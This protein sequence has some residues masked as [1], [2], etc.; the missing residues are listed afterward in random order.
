[1]SGKNKK[2]FEKPK[3]STKAASSRAAELLGG[4]FAGV[5]AFKANAALA[6]SQFGRVENNDEY[7]KETNSNDSIATKKSPNSESFKIGKKTLSQTKKF[8]LPHNSPID[9]SLASLIKRM[10]KKDV[11]TRLKTLDE[12]DVYVLKYIKIK[13]ELNQKPISYNEIEGV[14]NCLLMGWPSVFG[15][16][17]F[18]IDRRIRLSILKVHRSFISICEKKSVMVLSQI[19]GPWLASFFDLNNEISKLSSSVFDDNFGKTDDQKKRVFGFCQVGILEFLRTSLIDSNEETF[20]DKRYS[21]QEELK[22]RYQMVIG[23]S[24]K[25][26]EFLLN[27]VEKETISKEFH[28]YQ[29]LLCTQKLWKNFIS[30]SYESSQVIFS[31]YSCFSAFMK[32][33]N[34]YEFDVN[35]CRNIAKDVI[36]FSLSSKREASSQSYL[37]DSVV[38]STKAFP[39]LW[40]PENNSTKNN[41][42][43]YLI[44]YFK[45]GEANLSPLVSYPSLYLLLNFI[46]ADVFIKDNIGFDILSAVWLGAPLEIKQ[47]LPG[48][49]ITQPISTSDP[50]EVAQAKEVN[51][52]ALEA[53]NISINSFINSICECSLFMW[54]VQFKSFYNTE[55]YIIEKENFL[56]NQISSSLDSILNFCIRSVHQG[57][58]NKESKVS[59][60]IIE[61]IF[62]NTFQKLCQEDDKIFELL[63]KQI[64]SSF[65]STIESNI[66]SPKFSNSAIM[67]LSLLSNIK[68][69][70]EKHSKGK[71]LSDKIKS[72]LYS[73]EKW[74]KLL[75]NKYYKFLL[76]DIPHLSDTSDLNLKIHFTKTILSFSEHFPDLVFTQNQGI[77][78]DF[79]DSN[80]SLEN[81]NITNSSE[82]SLDSITK[83]YLEWLKFQLDKNL[84]MTSFSSCVDNIVLQL[85]CS[86]GKSFDIIDNLNSKNEWWRLK[87]LFSILKSIFNFIKLNENKSKILLDQSL[88]LSFIEK[89]VVDLL[90]KISFTQ[91]DPKFDMA[92]LLISNINDLILSECYIKQGFVSI[93]NAV[94]SNDTITRIFIHFLNSVKESHFPIQI[95]TGEQSLSRSD[96]GAH[97]SSNKMHILSSSLSKVLKGFTIN[98]SVGFLFV[99]KLLEVSKKLNDKSIFFLNLIAFKEA[100]TNNEI[101]LRNSTKEIIDSMQYILLKSS[102]TPSI[103]EPI[104]LIVFYFESLSKDLISSITS[105]LSFTNNEK[106]SYNFNQLIESGICLANFAYSL[107]YPKSRNSNTQY[108]YFGLVMK[109]FFLIE[110]GNNTWNIISDLI[111]DCFDCSDFYT[112]L[113]DRDIED[114]GLKS[115]ALLSKRSRNQPKKIVQIK[116]GLAKL[117]SF[118]GTILSESIKFSGELSENI[119][120]SKELFLEISDNN[121]SNLDSVVSG[122]ASISLILQYTS[123]SY[124]DTKLFRSA[125]EV[126]TFI[127][128]SILKL[129][130]SDLYETKQSKSWLKTLSNCL[131]R[132]ESLD[133]SI[134]ASIIKLTNSRLD[135]R[136]GTDWNKLLFWTQVNTRIFEY[137]S[138]IDLN[139][140]NKSEK[141]TANFNFNYTD[142]NDSNLLDDHLIY[143]L[144]NYLQEKGNNRYDLVIVANVIGVIENFYVVDKVIKISA[145]IENIVKILLK[146]LEFSISSSYVEDSLICS[147][148]LNVF[149][150][151][152]GFQNRVFLSV[153]FSKMSSLLID[154]VSKLAP[155]GKISAQSLKLPSNSSTSTTPR[156]KSLATND[157]YSYSAASIASD[158]FIKIYS[159]SSYQFKVDYQHSIARLAIGW[160]FEASENSTEN[161]AKLFLA[162]NA[163]NLIISLIKMGNTGELALESI[164]PLLDRF[165]ST[166]VPFVISLI[167][168]TKNDHL[169]PI[170]KVFVDS[171]ILGLELGIDTIDIDILENLDILG[172][173]VNKSKVIYSQY[174]RLV[175][176]SSRLSKL[177][178]SEHYYLYLEKYNRL[179]FKGDS[180][181]ADKDYAKIMEN[182]FKLVKSS[183]SELYSSF[184]SSGIN[185]EKRESS[186]QLYQDL[187]LIDVES[188][189]K[190]SISFDRAFKRWLINLW[191]LFEIFE[192]YISD[193]NFDEEDPTEKLVAM[194]EKSRIFDYIM[195][196]MG[197]I[198][199]AVDSA[200]IL[201]LFSYLDFDI[202]TLFD[203]QK[204]NG[205]AH[206]I[207]K[208]HILALSQFLF[209]ILYLFP[210]F[211]RTYV[212]NTENEPSTKIAQF[213]GSK[214]TDVAV[215][216]TNIAHKMS[217][218]WFSEFIIKNISVH[219]I[220]REFLYLDPT[221][222]QEAFQRSRVVCGNSSY[223]EELKG[224]DYKR[225][226]NC[227]DS[228]KYPEV[229]WPQN[230]DESQS[231]VLSLIEQFSEHQQTNTSLEIEVKVTGQLVSFVKG[232]LASEGTSGY[233]GGGKGKSG[234][235]SGPSTSGVNNS[236]GLSI[237][238]GTVLGN[239]EIKFDAGEY[240][241]S[242]VNDEQQHEIKGLYKNKHK[243]RLH[244][245]R[246]S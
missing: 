140:D 110:K 128:T 77:V 75:S 127:C 88:N 67:L 50:S 109:T 105:Q 168:G 233:S 160:I 132:P 21:D 15:S 134:F 175:R 177:E 55:N 220:A 92:K 100:K 198:L 31:A 219:L 41:L 85:F 213:Y 195:I 197:I 199:S 12:I 194:I 97:I 113:R 43:S 207:N 56:N 242:I 216:V 238:S 181:D 80:A 63:N 172:L 66:K 185:F 136:R 145:Q 47:T 44:R 173:S 192:K 25:S 18:D 155:I 217:L 179:L 133:Q 223:S 191:T 115:L 211:C 42:I 202:Q 111:D 57:S 103:D 62:G 45:S 29:E 46:P 135:F 37:W 51:P 33:I 125:E 159:S 209:K 101:L 149:L 214:S 231:E 243:D 201:K 147:S 167:K 137:C 162:E 218:N 98:Y 241:L 152:S 190:I 130:I 164:R 156:G 204:T 123:L 186:Q 170:H 104:E 234:L 119:F 171:I 154:L 138:Y 222:L 148:L 58:E 10:G 65:E 225:V 246:T 11:T 114:S 40:I 183:V 87:L 17:I 235:A 203:H 84:D 205:E 19:M 182:H 68:E 226:I 193:N 20:A 13:E 108:N 60:I 117:T 14:I 91:T 5:N 90:E 228:L 166:A 143:P 70:L 240:N 52:K 7:A 23:Q 69:L 206:F 54:T 227:G 150:S 158:I 49:K 187:D 141:N 239:V 86:R 24:F 212:S 180:E 102:N 71:A 78:I 30:T 120:K 236:K 124:R 73:I 74:A 95:N 157:S 146:K 72:S 131:F 184:G 196:P 48:Y 126:C 210:S 28:I 83:Y 221:G 163:S 96:A 94:Y 81:N 165:F 9:E 2:T 142:S 232:E 237:G 6:F 245:Q 230:V 116:I 122:I 189:T 1:M 8:E 38:Y 34:R 3:Q 144:S 82:L 153:G 215:Y 59:S 174:F 22:F 53:K 27:N 169:E 208:H 99:L 229:A 161:D 107:S 26:L 139:N 200:Q 188:A 112:Y 93:S 32:K 16:Q 224:T 151:D 106:P 176:T 118:I 39:G 35:I 4:N 121:I 89:L 129:A 178:N 244:C 79:L 64:L 61:H 36:K 76:D